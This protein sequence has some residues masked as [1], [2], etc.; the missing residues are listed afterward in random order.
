MLLSVHEFP[1]VHVAIWRAKP[2]WPAPDPARR[3]AFEARVGAHLH[4]QG[5][6]GAELRVSAR[7]GPAGS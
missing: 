4:A 1:R 5:L 6:L 2:R 3:A 7:C